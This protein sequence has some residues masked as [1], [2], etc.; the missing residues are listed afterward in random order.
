MAVLGPGREGQLTAMFYVAA[1]IKP[2]MKGSECGSSSAS[3][4][5]IIPVSLGIS[6]SMRS[7][8]TW[9]STALPPVSRKASISAE[10]TCS[11]GSTHNQRRN[12]STQVSHI[13]EMILS[14][15]FLF[16]TVQGKVSIW[17]PL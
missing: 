10:N 1:T 17:K 4:T 14:C 9:E 6:I 15:F 7:W 12:I 5:A 3:I 2:E 8:E 13:S 16:R 11:Q